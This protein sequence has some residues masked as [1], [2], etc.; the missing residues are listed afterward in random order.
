VKLA[1]LLI[2]AEIV[3]TIHYQLNHVLCGKAGEKLKNRLALVV[4][5]ICDDPMN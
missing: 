2:M 4:A 1:V 3:K 5:K